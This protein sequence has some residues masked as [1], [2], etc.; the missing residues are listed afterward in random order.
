[1]RSSLFQ[2]GLTTAILAAVTPHATRAADPTPVPH[3][4]AST[5]P[6]PSTPSTPPTP[7]T[8]E[9]PPL[10]TN[11]LVAH[12]VTAYENQDFRQALDLIR[13][14]Q[15][16]DPKKLLYD[17]HNLHNLKGA[18]YVGLR[19]FT[20][21]RQAFEAAAKAQPKDFDCQ[22]NL[23]EIE[24][25]QGH[26]QTAGESF[27]NLQQL[28]KGRL[29]YDFLQFKIGM[30]LLL[31]GDQEAFQTR[32]EMCLPQSP[33]ELFLTLADALNRSDDEKAEILM[34]A[35]QGKVD[36]RP[37]A[38][39]QDSLVE[40]G[41]IDPTSLPDLSATAIGKPDRIPLAAGNAPSL[42][43]GGEPPAPPAPPEQTADPTSPPSGETT[44]PAPETETKEAS[45]TKPPTAETKEKTP[46]PAPDSVDQDRTERPQ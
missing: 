11:T 28:E 10:S 25:L 24:Y 22:F 18:C 31:Q 34:E 43:T 38:L 3:L 2:I 26:Y 6:A 36:P 14:T 19:L 41:L 15:A 44:E 4:P 20:H 45:G 16:R 8:P 33:N 13:Q 40:G 7:S 9:P 46:V 5:P 30:C 42:P 32:L 17:N 29:Y 1:M 37:F 39:Y 27:S 23:A 35:V 21:A 12:A